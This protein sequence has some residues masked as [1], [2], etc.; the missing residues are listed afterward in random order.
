MGLFAT[1]TFLVL[2]C[3]VN[4]A[5]LSRPP[6]WWPLFT[7]LFYA[8]HITSQQTKRLTSQ[9]IQTKTHTH[10]H[11]HYVRGGTEHTHTQQ[12]RK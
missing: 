1:L 9:T 2:A 11:T 10:T 12:Q 7:L 5:D 6:K 4:G 3:T 8:I